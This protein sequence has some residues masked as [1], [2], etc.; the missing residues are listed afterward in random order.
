MPR[1]PTTRELRADLAT[2]LDAVLR[3]ED[4]QIMRDNVW[5]RVKL[6]PVL[7]EVALFE[8]PSN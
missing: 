5:Y 1:R 4:V 2:Y 6:E 7:P 8:I 3:G